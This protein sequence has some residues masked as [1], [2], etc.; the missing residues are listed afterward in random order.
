MAKDDKAKK[1]KKGQLRFEYAIDSSQELVFSDWKGDKVIK[2]CKTDEEYN[3][4]KDKKVKSVAPPVMMASPTIKKT[5][6]K[7]ASK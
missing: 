2:H 7:K 1:P 3:D 5:T 6:K 4:E